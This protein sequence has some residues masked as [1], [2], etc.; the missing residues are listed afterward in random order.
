[1][2]YKLKD[3]N[4]VYVSLDG[5]MQPVPINRVGHAFNKLTS[6]LEDTKNKLTFVTEDNK[7][8]RSKIDYLLKMLSGVNSTEKV[9]LLSSKVKESNKKLEANRIEIRSLK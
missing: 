1:M 8:L 6:E 2:E 4:I 5:D 7:Y 9:K 3:G